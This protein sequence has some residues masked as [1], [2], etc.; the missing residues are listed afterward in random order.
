MDDFLE[1]PSFLTW[2]L[3]QSGMVVIL[4]AWVWSLHRSLRTS[5]QAN[6]ALQLRNSELASSLVDCVVSSSRE[7]ASNNEQN[8]KAVLDSF[9]SALHH[10]LDESA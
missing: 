5:L 3:G 8:L 7:R 2:V 10:K 6:Q 4:A 9:E 1:S